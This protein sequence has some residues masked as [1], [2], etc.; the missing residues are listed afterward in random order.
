MKELEVGSAA[1]ADGLV[2]LNGLQVYCTRG[3]LNLP[4]AL[5]L[6]ACTEV[7]RCLQEPNIAPV[8]H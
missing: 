3:S 1:A 2:D 4:P 8:I 6:K 5:Q 7:L